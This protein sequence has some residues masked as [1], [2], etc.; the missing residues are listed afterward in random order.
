MKGLK[1]HRGRRPAGGG[2]TRGI[3]PSLRLRLAA[4]YGGLVLLAGIVLLAV[5]YGLVSARGTME[6]AVNVRSSSALKA[7]PKPTLPPGATFHVR[8]GKTPPLVIIHPAGGSGTAPAPPAGLAQIRGALLSVAQYQQSV[9]RQALLILGGVALLLVTGLALLAGWL[10]AGRILRPLQIMTSTARRLSTETPGGRFAFTGPRDEMKDLADTFDAFLD[11]IDQALAAERRFV[12]NASHELR[13]PLAVQKTLLEVGLA[14]RDADAATL[15]QLAERLWQLNQRSRR[16]IDGLLELAKS[17][18][19]ISA[20]EPVDLAQIAQ[21]ALESAADEAAAGSV[22]VTEHLGP[23]AASGDRALLLR[24]CENL[25]EN[26][27]RHNVAGGWLRVTT[28]AEGPM[29]V[30]TVENSG[31]VI[32]PQTVDELFTPF[33][34]AAA[35]RTESGRGAGLGLSIVRAIAQAH[36]GEVTATARPEGGLGVT[37]RLPLAG[38][39]RRD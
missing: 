31:P 16:L 6:F 25:V 5:T 36:G 19:G 12:A 23:A 17:E 22:V 38:A 15:R 29:A 4:L 11:R 26:A 33:R 37:V 1:G 27:V 30:L 2:A 24:L 3:R 21:D 28:G 32:D 35:E 8:T 7:L 39:G 10:V 18:Q 14:D 9:D 20:A 34:R 13:T